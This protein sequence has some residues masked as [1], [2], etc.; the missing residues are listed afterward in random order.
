MIGDSAGGNLAAAVSLM[1]RDRG[2]FLPSCQILIYPATGNDHSEHSPFPSVR[3]NGTDYLLTTKRVRDYM[4][5]YRSS[6]ADLENPYYAP[7]VA[8]DLSNQP[9]TLIITAEYCPLRD[10]GEAYG[11]ALELAGNRVKV[12]RMPDA[13]HGY[14]SLPVRFSQVKKT[15]GL[16]NDFL[17]ERENEQVE[18]SPAFD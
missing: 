17:R 9:D 2:E 8:K 6:E 11:K 12:F 18:I 14:F 1:A 7:L 16:I 15:Y 3:E 10:E 13:L 5:L 4:E